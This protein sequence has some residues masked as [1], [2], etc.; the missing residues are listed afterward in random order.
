MNRLCWLMTEFF[1]RTLAPGE[2]EAVLGDLEECGESAPA[3]LL[4]LL[5]LFVRRQAALWQHWHPWLGLLGVAGLAGLSLGRF[6]LLLSEFG[7][8]ADQDVQTV[9]CSL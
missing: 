8:A 5:S 1:S 2:R 4:H 3:A 7:N 6:V 9:R